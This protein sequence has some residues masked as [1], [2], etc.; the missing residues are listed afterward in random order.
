[1]VALLKLEPTSY[2]FGIDA[3]VRFEASSNLAKF[4]KYGLGLLIF[5]I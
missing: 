1:M 2:R 5:G 3:L 4:F